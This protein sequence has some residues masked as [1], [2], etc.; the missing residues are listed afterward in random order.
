MGDWQLAVF[1]AAGF[2]AAI[3]SGISGGGAG[4]ITTPL[5]IFLGLT[6]GQ[7]VSIGKFIGL[8]ATVG[9][10]TGLRGSH[11]KVSV[12]RVLPVMV[13]ALAIGLVV[14]FIIK[15]LDSEVYK[16]ILGAML[17]LMSPV[18]IYKKIGIKPH[19]PRLWQKYIGGVLLAG[20]LFLQ[21]AFSGGLG[22]LVNLV[23]M[24][25]LGMS[26]I[27]A[28]ITKRWSQLILNTSIIFGVVGSGLII[29]SIL[30]VVVV[31]HLAGSYIGGRLA[32]VKGDKFIINIMV[33]LMLVSGTALIFG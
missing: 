24:G 15:S 31:C 30:P 21:G 1:G 22:T 12:R 13:L 11:S 25:M 2:I 6:P 5:G 16:N 28:N 23:L 3:L 29:W 33:F 18:I 7:S 8:S 32:H 14:P 26:A 27:E 17:I 20:S 10:L 9:S 4:F 19:H